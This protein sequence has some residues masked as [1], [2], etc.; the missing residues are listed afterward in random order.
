YKAEDVF[1]SLHPTRSGTVF[2]AALTG[3]I[4]WA[5]SLAGGWVENFAVYRRLPQAIAEHRLGR[6]LGRRPLAWASGFFARNISGLGGSVALGVMLGMTPPVGAFF[7]LPLDVRHV[8][9]ATGQ[10]AFAIAE[11]GMVNLSRPEVGWAAVGIA[12]TFVF[13]LGTSFFL[14]LTVAL[15]AR[16]VPRR[17]RWALVRAIGLH[18]LRHPRDFFWPPRFDPAPRVPTPVVPPKPPAPA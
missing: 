11:G 1:A 7:G 8:T 4:L 6:W 13:N 15:R 16:Q 9:L 17:D 10:L 2:F 12:L 5:A 18:F 14:A 3:V